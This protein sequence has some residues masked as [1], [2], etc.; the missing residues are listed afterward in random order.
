MRVKDRASALFI[1]PLLP[2]LI[3]LG[4]VGVVAGCGSAARATPSSTGATATSIDFARSPDGGSPASCKGWSKDPSSVIPKGLVPKGRPVLAG[5]VSIGCG[6]SLGE[7]VRLVAYVEATAH[8]GEQLCYVVEQRRRSSTVGGSCIQTN[9]SIPKCR[10]SCP[11]IV[12]ATPAVWGKEASKGSLVTAA[13]P[14]VMEE[15][16]LSTAPLGMERVTR[17]AIVVL[18][19]PIK[20]ELRLP[21]VVSLFASIVIPCLPPNQMVSARNAISGETFNMEGSD[22]FG[23]R[24]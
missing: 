20:E 17:R 1:R 11:L 14:G 8:G 12:E 9:P 15:V 18:K 21:S 22:P 10:E 13:A 7:P 3:C 2:L 5:P 24:A 23:C 16:S 4:L 19:G 6:V